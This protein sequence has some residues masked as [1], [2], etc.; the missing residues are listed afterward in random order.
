[1]YIIEQSVGFCGHD[2]LYKNLRQ[3]DVQY[4]IPKRQN[5]LRLIRAFRI[6]FWDFKLVHSLGSMHR[7]LFPEDTELVKQT[8]DSRA[9]V[10]MTYKHQRMLLRVLCCYAEH[11]STLDS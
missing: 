3:I 4:L 7:I 5:V 11:L 6:A 1:M 10:E 2:N 9:D 8:H